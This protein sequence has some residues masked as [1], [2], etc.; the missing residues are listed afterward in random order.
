MR[1]KTRAGQYT[2][3]QHGSVVKQEKFTSKTE[4]YY[5]VHLRDGRMLSV[6]TPV[7]GVKVDNHKSRTT[8]G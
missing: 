7:P 8:I 3:I 1:V 5:V 2:V 6:S 4:T